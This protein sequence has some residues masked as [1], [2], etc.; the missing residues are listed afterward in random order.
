MKKI[1]GFL[2]VAATLVC[3]C[4]FVAGCGNSKSKEAQITHRQYGI[5]QLKS[6]DFEGAVK[7]FQN[8]LDQST[9]GI[10]NTEID[11]CLYKA[12]AQYLSGD[13]DGAKETYQAMIDYKE[14]PEVY[15]QRGCFYYAIGE[16]DAG[17]KD[18]E[19]AISL[20]PDNTD[21]YIGVYENIKKNGYTDAPEEYLQKA[22][23]IEGSSSKDFINKGRI[24]LLLEEY[25]K[26][27]ENL[28]KA[29]E[30]GDKEANF[31]LA[32]VYAAMGE[33]EQSEKSFAEYTKSG[34]A[35]AAELCSMADTLMKRD[36]Y[37]TALKYLEA[38]QDLPSAT[39]IR[40]IKKSII[41]CY[42]RTGDYANAQTLMSSY[43]KEYPD[44]EDAK[45]D[46]TF[47]KT[48]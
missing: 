21:L 16:A 48:R 2:L 28:N 36:D 12:R 47:L 18:F 32:I 14:L 23:A 27:I 38:A 10:G 3:V 33:E 37:K 13:L 6:G 19:K 22:L 9:W 39:D 42:E 31:Y 15:Y 4:G 24:Y 8:A 44:D 41:I 5:A 7:S 45:R 25:D 35:S 20:A 29:V 1:N 30:K 46:Y 17:F 43:L 26:A 11:I 40:S 34:D